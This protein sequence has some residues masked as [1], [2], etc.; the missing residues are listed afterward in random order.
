MYKND[1]TYLQTYNQAIEFNNQLK[2]YILE[3]GQLNLDESMVRLYSNYEIQ[4]RMLLKELV[5]CHKGKDCVEQ[6]KLKF[7]K[8][9]S[10]TS[11][12]I[13]ANN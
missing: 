11:K 7:E 12:I 8:L 1:K 2:D 6:F 9:R 4:L 5:N 13:N 3:S 10:D